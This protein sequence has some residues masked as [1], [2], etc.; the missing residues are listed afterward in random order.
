MSRVFNSKKTILMGAAL[1]LS[2]MQIESFAGQGWELITQLP[3]KRI[4]FSTAVVGDKIY[5]IGGTL[6]INFDGPFG[7]STVEEYDTQTNTWRRRTDMPT[8]RN[9]PEAAVVN[10]IIYVFGGSNAKDRKIANMKLPVSVEAYDPETDTWTRKK[11]MPVSRINFE[12]GVAA[13][14]VYLIGGS[15]GL[16]AEHE[17]R[18]DRV[19]VYDPAT[20]TW[21]KGPKMP[22]RREPRAVEVVNDRI[23]VIGG[24]GWPPPPAGIGRLLQT[25]EEYDPISR[26][27]RK[28]KDMLD[29]SYGFSTAVVEDEIYLFGGLDAFRQYLATASVY[30]PQKGAWRDNPKLPTPMYPNGAATVNG[31]IYVFGGFEAGRD[32]SDVLVYDTGFR[33]VTA[34]GKL[35]TR[36]G[37]LKAEPQRRPQRD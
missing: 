8:P 9:Y 3:T 20:D 18:M 1:I 14:K 37:E 31:K 28:K 33:A 30:N 17:R 4:A 35:F 2:L 7:L 21:T 29:V 25:I 34:K 27:W 6:S 15:T 12:L 24:F 16:G 5:L 26:Q 32:S 13:G 19:D 10:G 22:T 36:W 11:D 23:Y